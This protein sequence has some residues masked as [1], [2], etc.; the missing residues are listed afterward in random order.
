[1]LLSAC[2]LA[3]GVALGSAVYLWAS[4]VPLDVQLA[5]LLLAFSTGVLVW[6]CMLHV[7]QVG[8]LPFLPEAAQQ[9]L[10]QTTLLEWFTDA[11]FLKEV[12][13]YAPLLLGLSPE[14]LAEYLDGVPPAFR[15]RLTRPGMLHLLP[16]P[17]QAWMRPSDD[18]H[19]DKLE[20][21]A[22]HAGH[23]REEATGDQEPEVTREGTASDTTSDRFDAL[24][25]R[26][27]NQRARGSLLRVS[28]AVE[29][30][31]PMLTRVALGG[32]ALLLLR[33]ALHRR[34]RSA[35]VRSAVGLLTGGATLSVGVLW[36][37]LAL[38]AWARQRWQLQS[39]TRRPAARRLSFG[40]R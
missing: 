32:T 29:E 6:C 11:P 25:G 24:L 18:Q 40:G 34:A 3:G 1:M 21:T 12:R 36:I 31:S 30:A 38:H 26:I 28:A 17:W 4:L 10:L 5:L 8:L 14:E 7:K 19:G 9:L 2:T 20:G 22:P 39:A 16:A 35:A 23:Q 37:V 33:F 15:Q 27:L 13:K